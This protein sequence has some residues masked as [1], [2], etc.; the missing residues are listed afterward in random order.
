MVFKKKVISLFL[1]LSLV[2]P[3]IGT[4]YSYAEEKSSLNAEQNKIEAENAQKEKVSK[5]L[6]AKFDL[7]KAEGDYVASQV[8]KYK[9][10]HNFEYA[11]KEVLDY[12][13]DEGKDEEI[14]QFKDSI[15]SRADQII[16]DYKKA[17]EE[18]D[19]E[20]DDLGYMPGQ[21]IV[22]FKD[23]VDED[24]QD[25]VV[26]NLDGEID[27]VNDDNVGVIDISNSETVAKA[28]ENYEDSDCIESV[29]PNFVYK[30]VSSSSSKAASTTS[31]ND[32]YS[33]RQ[34]Y[35][36]KLKIY[37]AWDYLD[38]IS[39]KKVKVA[40]LD[41]GLDV[42][43]P[44]LQDNL[45]LAKDAVNGFTNLKKDR[46]HH[47]THV[48]GILAATTNNSTG[49]AGVGNNKIDLIAINVFVGSGEDASAL[50]SD[51]LKGYKYAV[52]KGAKVINMSLGRLVDDN[53]YSTYDQK[54]DKLLENAIE[55][56]AAKGVVTVCAAG[57]DNSTMKFYPAD[58]DACISVI[59]IDKD[60]QKAYDSNYGTRKD[61]SAY[62]REIYSTIPYSNGKRYM[63]DS[64]TSMASPIVAGVVALMKSKNPYA[65][66]EDIKSTLY[67]TADD[68]GKAG[69]DSFTGY[70]R[71]NALE[72]VK[73]TK[74]NMA[75]P[76]IDTIDSSDT[77]V[78][79]TASSYA[80]IKVYNASG[81]LIG[82]GKA[83][84][85]GKYSISI[86]KQSGG[87]TIKVVASKSGYYSKSATKTVLKR[88]TAT[89]TASTI[90]STTTK[91][92]GKGSKG[93]TIRAYVNGKQIGS[94]TTVKST[95]SYTLT[96]PKQKK[97]T[98]VTI[99]M[100]KTGYVSKSITRTVK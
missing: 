6:E 20:I 49:I 52:E 51:I 60:D 59:N 82:S 26:A 44:D 72:A 87:T 47:G 79:G 24:L 64:G 94:S 45:Y 13:Y 76:T 36:E 43:H 73:A 31:T 97:K 93:A 85:A 9:L 99:K 42:N 40:V 74:K 27:Q 68:I 66:V 69:K 4:I 5:Q 16:K 11:V 32:K 10:D 56:A 100:S 12:Y 81:A 41:T 90:Y 54:Q 2:L 83:S 8:N 84:S 58:F 65:S 21:V 63:Y 15:D 62:G 46:W 14:E 28:L 86:P 18:R 98:V 57:N 53:F 23:D 67:S 22:E 61:I 34:Y 91:V 39:T 48:S 55:D 71:V 35:L 29:Q 50:T 38:T 96:I 80:T 78:T 19:S 75:S 37:D 89:F 7:E 30:L 1:S 25:A 3:N 17:A 33:S 88:F 70:G 95:G 77:V 92:T